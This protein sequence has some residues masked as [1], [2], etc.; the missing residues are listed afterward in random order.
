MD[1]DDELFITLTNLGLLQAR[2]PILDVHTIHIHGG[3]VAT[4]LDGVP[5]TSFGVPV[6]PVGE[7]SISV[8]YYFK[9]EIPLQPGSR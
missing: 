1:V 2:E 5:E 7:P 9:P 4:Q 6:T 3:H 8:T